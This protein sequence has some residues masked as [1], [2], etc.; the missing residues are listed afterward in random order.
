VAVIDEAWC[1]GCTLCLK[2]C[3]VDS[4]VGANKRMH[5]VV[6][7]QC[8]GCE[9]CIPVCPVSCIAMEAVSGQRTGWAAWSE[10]QAGE[11]RAR[12][13]FHQLRVQRDKREHDQALLAKAVHKL[14]DLENQ[15]LHTDPAVIARKRSVIEAAIARARALRENASVDDTGAP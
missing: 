5:T 9:L 4:I 3:P 15:T 14:S 7:A 2:A 12:Y 1:I 8:T 11:A 13:A 10:T 6:E